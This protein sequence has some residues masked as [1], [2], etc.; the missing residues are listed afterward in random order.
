MHD[1]TAKIPSGIF[2]GNVNQYGDFDQCLSI[3]TSQLRGKYCIAYLQPRSRNGTMR[4]LLRLAQSYEFFKSNFK[5]VGD[6]Y[7]L[8]SRASIVSEPAF[9]LFS[10][11]SS[12]S[13]IHSWKQYGHRTPRFSHVNWAV[14]IPSTCTHEDLENGIRSYFRQSTSF[15]DI[16][17]DVK[18]DEEMCQLRQEFMESD[19]DRATRLVM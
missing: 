11:F 17:F 19:V 18:V 9:F 12:S 14:C 8:S 4:D 3:A 6:S 16:T 1:A 10:S 2:N 5:D 15:S 13:L 7:S